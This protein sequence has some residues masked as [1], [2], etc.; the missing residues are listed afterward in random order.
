MMNFYKIFKIFKINSTNKNNFNLFLFLLLFLTISRLIPHEPNFTPILSV[1]ILGFLFS[2]NFLKKIF[3]IIGSMIIS[4]LIIGVHALI[5]YIYFSIIIIILISNKKNYF[6]MVF[7]GPCIFF[8]ISN[9]GEWI[10][11]SYYAKDI[12]GLIECF[13]LA[14]PFFKNTLISTIFYCLFIIFVKKFFL[15]FKKNLNY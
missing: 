12:S 2:K 5:P 15:N 11:S 10:H 9:L 1:S 13:Y 3:L 6:Y 7:F 8:I 14:I 4:D